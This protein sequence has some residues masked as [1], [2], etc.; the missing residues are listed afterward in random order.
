MPI[1]EVPSMAV[2]RRSPRRPCDVPS[3][4][5]CLTHAR[6]YPSGWKCD[7]HSPWGR[8]GHDS[9]TPR[10]KNDPERDVND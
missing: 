9:P 3:A 7:R 1:R 6:L 8:A 10:V 2:R 5:V 4:T